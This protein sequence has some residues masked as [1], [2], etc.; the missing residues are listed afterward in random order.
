MAGRFEGRS[1]LVT[2]ACGGF[3]RAIATTF[4]GEGASL[5]LSDRDEGALAALAAELGG[6]HAILAA[7]VTQDRAH[8]GMVALAVERFDRLDVAVNNAGIVHG[9]AEL[10]DIAPEEAERVIAVD[11]M[12]AFRALRH[13]IPQMRRQ[14]ER[15]GTGGAIVNIASIAGVIGA[16]GLSAYAAAKHGVVGL[17]RSAA[18]ENARHGVRINAICPSFS[19]TPMVTETLAPDD[20]ERLTKGIPMRRFAAV[21]EVVEAVVFAAASENAFMTGQ[22]LNVDGGLTAG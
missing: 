7:D 10:P 3:G 2:G 1:V 5:V 16:A 9:F 11:L 8:A 12:G 20:H 17:T 19:P 15:T 14:F 13:Q 4:A 18:L 22:T 6:K 21:S